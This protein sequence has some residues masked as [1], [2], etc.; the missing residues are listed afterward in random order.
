[1]TANKTTRV[2]H[3]TPVKNRF[4]GAMEATGKLRQSGAKYGIKASTVSDIWTKYKN[5]NTTKNQPRSGRPSK[6]TDRA[7]RLVVRNC[8]KDRQKPFQK[9]AQESNMNISERL[10]RNVAVDTGYHR[11]VARKVPFLTA[12]QKKKRL[13]WA[14]EFKSFSPHK[15]GNL[16]WSDECYIHLGDHN[17]RVYVTRRA[18][19]EYNENCV[20]P[21]FKQ[22]SVCVMVWGCIMN[23]RKGPLVVLEYP[24]GRGGGMTGRR[25]VSQV[26]EAH[27]CT[28]Y[29]HMKEERPEVIFQQDGAP[30]HTSKLAKQWLVDHGISVFPHPPS[31]PDVNPIEPVWHELKKL[32]RALPRSP[33]TVLKLI[34]AVR[35]AWDT[36]AI[37][38]IDKYIHTMSDRVQAVLEADGSHTRF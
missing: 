7:Q 3:D 16:I 1:M 21:T 12:L 11:R 31:S 2:Q 22:S 4:I 30:S 15:W 19:E 13:A 17:G 25:Y 28:F 26:L 10:V 14:K 34:Q 38:D 37:P 5:T 33:T 20:I 6:L 23:G 35:D 18:D 9:V 32:I 24:G 29:H 8:I 36:L 27:L